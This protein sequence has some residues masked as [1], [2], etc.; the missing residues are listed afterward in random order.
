MHKLNYKHA[1]HASHHTR[2]PHTC[3]PCTTHCAHA[4]AYLDAYTTPHHP[5]P[6]H[7]TLHASHKCTPACALVCIHVHIHIHTCIHTCIHTYTCIYIYI[8]ILSTP[9]RQAH[10]T[11]RTNTQ[12]LFRSPARDASQGSSTVFLIKQGKN[13]K[14]GWVP[15]GHGAMWCRA[16]TD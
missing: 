9:Q 10:I 7:I 2:T 8:Y 5:T 11:P 3:M 16:K 14:A 4:H 12:T 13:A 6:R 15:S 1:L